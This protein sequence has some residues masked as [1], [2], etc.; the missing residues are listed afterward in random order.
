MARLLATLLAALLLAAPAHAS[1]VVAAP[2]ADG[3]VIAAD[4]RITFMGADCDG[5]FK[6]LSLARTA[7]TVVFVTGDS[8]FVPPPPAH[9][10][11]PCRYLATAPRLLDIGALVTRSLGRVPADPATV[12]LDDLAQQCV[13]AVERL[14]RAHPSALARYRGRDLFSVVLASYEPSTRTATLRNFVVRIDAAT[15]RIEAARFA[16]ITRT[17]AD[18]RGVWM[19]GETGYVEKNVFDGFARGFLAASTLNFVLVH[20]SVAATPLD[21][22]A[23]A[24]VNVIQAASIATQTV[25]APSGIGG[26][27]RA[28]LLGSAPRPQPLQ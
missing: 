18:S 10:P 6:I 26:P 4:S 21:Q 1:L 19:Y 27:I 5:A 16:R 17:P 2:S 23:A 24:A 9:T 20:Q 12:P 28:V 25:P 11:D 15:Q 22:A 7:R 14:R 8:V 13:R 3:L